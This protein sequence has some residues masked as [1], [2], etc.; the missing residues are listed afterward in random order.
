VVERD[1][2]ILQFIEFFEN[3]IQY[4]TCK[5]TRK[6]SRKFLS[7]LFSIISKS[8]RRNHI[9]LRRNRIDVNLISKEESSS[10]VNLKFEFKNQESINRQLKEVVA[11]SDDDRAEVQFS[12]LSEIIPFPSNSRWLIQRVFQEVYNVSITPY[13]ELFKDTMH[14]YLLILGTKLIIYF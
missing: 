1:H 4:R 10:A 14:I 12:I 3:V 6:S 13:S 8:R 7:I 5:L 9:D 11:F 2:I